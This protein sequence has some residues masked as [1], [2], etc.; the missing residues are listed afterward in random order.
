MAVRPSI[1]CGN[2]DSPV[3]LNDKF[4]AKC[5]TALVWDEGSGSAEVKSSPPSKI[6]CPSCGVA[7]A[8]VSSL[9]VGCGTNLRGV[10]SLPHSPSISKKSSPIPSQHSAK[11]SARGRKIESWKTL[12]IG[13][14]VVLLVL[15]GIGVLRNPPKE[16]APQNQP[17]NA[18]PEAGISPTLINDIAALQKNVD[19][20]PK[21]AELLLQLA[22]ALHDAKF[23][24]RAIETYKKY[25]LLKPSDPDARVD[26]AICY[27]ESGDSPTALKEMKTALKYDPKHQMAMFNMGIVNLNQGNLEQ[28]NEWFTKTVAIDPKSQI[29]QRAQQILSQHS[30]IPQ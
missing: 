19:A 11:K 28:S 29:A 8:A 30:T 14:A 6:V 22:N 2:C 20:N 25:L 27:F 10:T 15:L 9:C 1:L 26:M 24:P 16:M 5:G 12:S 21:N 3:T 23:M 7:N 17:L 4:C 13:G 18:S